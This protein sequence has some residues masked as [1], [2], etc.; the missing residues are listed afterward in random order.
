MKW[1][2]QF[3]GVVI[4][5]S[6]ISFVSTSAQSE[7]P[8]GGPPPPPPVRAIPGL[9]ADD[10]HPHACVDCHVVMKDYNMDVRLSTLMGQWT[11]GVEPKLLAAA[12]AAAQDSTKITGKHPVAKTALKNIPGGCLACHSKASKTAPPFARL[13][14]RIHLVGGD[15]N[16]Y[17][18][19]YQGD[20]THCHKLDTNTGSWSV[21]SGAEPSAAP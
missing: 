12:K 4:A 3:L 2:L 6:T 15:Q 13:M 20:C 11:Q 18:G 5:A 7:K 10:P 1:M 14:H 19:Y 16:L 9:T 17:M 21:P 8:Q